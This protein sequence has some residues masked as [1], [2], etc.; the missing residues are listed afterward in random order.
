MERITEFRKKLARLIDVEQRPETNQEF[1]EQVARYYLYENDEGEEHL[2]TEELLKDLNDFYFSKD[3]LDTAMY[4]FGG[5]GG[6]FWLQNPDLD[7]PLRAIQ[8]D[9]VRA[10]I[11]SSRE[12]MIPA[13]I[14]RD[15]LSSVSPESVAGYIEE[16][17]DHL[18]GFGLS[19]SIVGSYQQILEE[20]GL[21]AKA[22][23]SANDKEQTKLK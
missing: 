4:D 21:E 11:Q 8:L 12:L 15:E 16:S 18:Y 22:P 9:L 13:D 20:R 6:L 10:F 23:S 2:K 5:S 17:I 7:D 1:K 3:G 19:D 14:I